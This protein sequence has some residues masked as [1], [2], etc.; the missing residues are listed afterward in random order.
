MNA[1]GDTM[2]F[3][4]FSVMDH[5]PKLPR[6]L[7]G[8]YG[9]VLQ[10]CELAES[11]GYEAFFCA[12]H[13][14]HEY[15]AVADP[16]VFLTAVAARTK[17]LKVGPAVSL[18]TFHD[19]RTTAE[20]YATLDVLSG[21]RLLFGVGSGYLKHEFA[22]YDLD[23]ATKRDR[24]NERLAIVKRLLAGE[25]VTQ[26]GKFVRVKDVAL[27]VLPPGGRVPPIYVAVLAP[28]GCYWVGKQGDN[29]MTVPY[30][31]CDRWEEVGAMMA[32][33]RRGQAEAGR[34]ASADDHVFA[35]HTYVADS[36]AA[37]RAEAKEAYDLYVATRLYAK[38][39]TYEDVIRNGLALFGS[40]ET[41][42]AKVAELHRWGIRHIATLHNFGALDPALAERSITRFAREVMPMAQA[43]LSMKA[44]AE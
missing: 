42:A 2:R 15:G 41:V 29:I 39:H 37:A 10:Q 33:Y 13:H 9:E 38:G 1:P 16:A 7:P 43:M 21:G 28:E 44:A 34:P 35:F 32:S 31:S 17:R 20:S 6:T 5:Y 18:L 14:F 24:F 25:R 22:G 19:P 27:N 3:S 23:L 4:L 30:A 11:L 36:D 12:E 40:V 26:E 8:F